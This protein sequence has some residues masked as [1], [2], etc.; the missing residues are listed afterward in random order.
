MPAAAMTIDAVD[1][2][3]PPGEI[4]VALRQLTGTA[5]EPA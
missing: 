3:L 5:E 1:R 4:G 2:Q